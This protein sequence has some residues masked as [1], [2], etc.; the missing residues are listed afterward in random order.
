MIKELR[1]QAPI[2]LDKSHDITTFDCGVSELNLFLH[3]YALINSL[4][5]S[6]KTFVALDLEGDRRVVG[7][8]SLVAGAVE[9]NAV[10]PRVSKGLGK[11]PI[12]VIILARLAVDKDYQ[13]LGL[14]KGLLKDALLRSLNVVDQIGARA[15]AVHAKDEQAAAFYEQYDFQRSPISPVHLYLLMKDI[16]K[17]LG[18]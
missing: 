10:P 9:H 11:Y 4:N 8:Y 1:F 15:I 18:L 6:V 2:P 5:Q 12:P 16:R 13:G 7:F 14:G 17:T 3:K